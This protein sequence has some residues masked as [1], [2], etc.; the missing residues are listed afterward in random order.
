MI[1]NIVMAKNAMECAH[2]YINVNKYL[3]F[4]VS[5]C[6]S[7]CDII[8]FVHGFHYESNA[9]SCTFLFDFS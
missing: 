3:N 2:D 6:V 1:K 9:T 4:I 5:F 8:S 7:V